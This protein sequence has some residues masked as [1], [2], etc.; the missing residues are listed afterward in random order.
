MRKRSMQRGFH[1]AYSWCF[2]TAGLVRGL[3]R[4]GQPAQAGGPSVADMSPLAPHPPGAMP[5]V[6]VSTPAPTATAAGARRFIYIACPWTPIG[7]GMFKVA[8]YLIQ[9]QAR[10]PGDNPR[11]RPLDTRGSGS[12]ARSLLVLLSALVKLVRGRASGQLAGVHVNMAERLSLFRKSSVLV[13]CKALGLPSVLHLHAAQL[14]HSYRAFPA[15]A[16]ALVR[17]AF[18]LPDSV[19]VLGKTSAEFVMNELKV[20]PQ[21]VE[22]VINGVPEP[23]AAR[24]TPQAVQRVLFVGNL[25]ERKGVSDLLRALAQPALADV[26][27]VATFAGGGDVAGYRSMADRLGLG[28]RV[29]FEGWADQD[30][31]AALLAQA[32]VLVLPS[33]DEGLPLAILEALAHGVAVVCTPVGEIPHVLSDGLNARFVKPGDAPAIA[34]GLA[35]VLR[36][37]QLRERL[38]RN[39]RALYEQRFSMSR[40]FA[41]IASVHRRHFGLCGGAAQ[42]RAAQERQP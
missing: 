17:W 24:R 21:R 26:P 40:F 15:P 8:D 36:D 4:Q 38:E 37:T 12:P 9:S 13:A 16:Q 10:L 35:D 18:S 11:L 2:N 28:E 39:G 31:V 27:L 32:D 3:L 33:Y 34:Q 25:S 1:A 22:I 30:Q 19:V 20:P 29:R 7:G 23:R 42:P 5:E 14:H 41:S 6:P